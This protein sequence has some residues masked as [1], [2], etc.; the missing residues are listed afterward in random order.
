MVLVSFEL[1]LR[2]KDLTICSE[3][4]LMRL[5][6]VLK[7]NQLSLANDSL[8]VHLFQDV[9]SREILASF[10]LKKCTEHPTTLLTSWG[11]D[12]ANQGVSQGCQ[13]LWAPSYP[14]FE[15]PSFSLPYIRTLPP[16]LSSTPLC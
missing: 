14:S 8:Q 16:V 3:C 4:L 10:V 11:Q 15:H 6:K 5:Q 9:E 2:V 1:F 13:S 12:S 7:I